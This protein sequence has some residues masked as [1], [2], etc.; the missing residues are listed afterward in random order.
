MTADNNETLSSDV[1]SALAPL[2]RYG[3]EIATTS[4]ASRAIRELADRHDQLAQFL[5]DMVRGMDGYR[6]TF[7]LS[8]VELGALSEEGSEDLAARLGGGAGS[9][10]MARAMA[11]VKLHQLAVMEGHYR[12]TSDGSR[13]LLEEVDPQAVAKA[14][15]GQGIRVGPVKLPGSFK[16]VLIQAVWEEILRRF[17]RLRRLESADFDR[18]FREGFRAGYRECVEAQ[19]PEAVDTP[20]ETQ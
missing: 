4:E 10:D 7:G 9:D 6:K 20:E 14:A 15:A 19:R 18:F 12:A 17:D 16:P 11:E 2:E 5:G 8:T 13:R 1:R 3:G